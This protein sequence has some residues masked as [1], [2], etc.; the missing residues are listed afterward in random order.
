MS[1]EAVSVAEYHAEL[2]RTMPERG[3]DGLQNKV[4]KMALDLNWRFYHAFDSRRSAPGFPDCLMLRGNRCIAM[5]LKRQDKDPT[6]EQ[7]EWLV[8]FKQ[9]GC[10]AYVFRPSDLLDGTILAVL[11]AGEGDDE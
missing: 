5:E 4:R 7:C 2:A 6:E 10:E 9:A 1:G 11:A 8:A 3:R